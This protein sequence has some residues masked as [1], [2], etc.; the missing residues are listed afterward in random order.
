MI[1]ST[2]VL[3]LNADDKKKRKSPSASY[4][5]GYL[6]PLI[7]FG[8]EEIDIL[9]KKLQGEAHNYARGACQLLVDKWLLH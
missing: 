7:L 3:N 6:A 9:L 5:Y 1:D 4:K 2:E 8:Q